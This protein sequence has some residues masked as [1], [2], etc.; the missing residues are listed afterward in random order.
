MQWDLSRGTSI[1]YPFFQLSFDSIHSIIALVLDVLM[2]VQTLGFEGIL[3]S[4][5]QENLSIG[6]RPCHTQNSL[7]SYRDKLENRNCL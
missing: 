5:T 3:L 1:T 6:V 4:L 7:V 2:F